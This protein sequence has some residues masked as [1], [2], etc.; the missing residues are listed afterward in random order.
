MTKVFVV[1]WFDC[2]DFVTPESDDA[3]KRLA[4]ILKSN[5]IKG[6][7]KLVGEKLRTLEK[8]KRQDVLNVLKD[9]EVGF[10]TNFH[11]V[12]PTVAEYLKDMD[13]ESGALEFLRR[14]S[15]GVEDIKR[16]FGVNPSCYGQPGGAW[17]PQVYLAL[18][19]LSIPV[20]LDSSDF[21]NLNGNPFWYCGILNILNLTGSR[22]GILGL[23][24]E[25]GMQGF[26]EEAEKVF[27]KAYNRIVENNSWGIISIFNHP[28]TLVTKEFWDAVNFSKGV[29]TPPDQLKVPEL[30]PKSWVEAGYDDFD[31][32]IKHV[33]SKPFVEVVTASDLYRIFKDNALDKVFSKNEIFSLASSL[34][35]I[36]FREISN[37]YVSASEIF[38][39][40]TAS[41]AEYRVCGRLPDKVV[42]AYPLGPYKPFSSEA[43]R[44]VKLEDFLDASYNAKVFMELN[45]RIPDFIKVGDTK[46]SPID[47]LSSEA[48][49]YTMLYNQKP[50]KYVELVEGVF[51]PYY[52]V[53]SEGAKNSWKWVIFPENFEAWNLVELAKLQTW[54]IKPAKPSFI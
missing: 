15:Q 53:S 20:Y 48:R 52:F 28:C 46:I 35:S 24:F 29:N 30:K 49:L 42:N 41:L 7:F 22:G 45:G 37:A 2:E 1:F 31:R 17:A 10:H 33:K 6:V 34:S 54:T 5:S 36:S 16:V 39:L 9:H 26:I 25:L 13:F 32:F 18:K 19:K 23:N 11:S 43:L 38:W 50:P 44:T 27:D 21:V 40:V 51:E 8:R 4:E 12:H 3:L 14:E 47:F